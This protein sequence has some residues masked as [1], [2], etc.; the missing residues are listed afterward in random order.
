VLA[1]L[2]LSQIGE[3]SFILART[4]AEFDL[5]SGRAFQLFLDVT[6]LTMMA[7]PLII[8]AGPL[9]AQVLI[10]LPL[11]RSLV[12]GWMPLPQIV[13]VPAKDHLIIVGFGING[14]NV[15]RA[16]RAANIAY[17]II[18]TNP[19]TVRAEQAKGEPII[20]GDATQEHV[21]EHA[22]IADARVMAIAISDP[23]A[24]RRV[25]EVARRINP[26]LYIIV[27]T[28][29]LQEIE[30]LRQLGANE[31]IPEEFETSIE[32][33]S[34]VLATYLIPE[35]DIERFINEVRADSY[36]MLRSIA[37]ARPAFTKLGE[38][39]ADIELTS[40]RVGDNSYVAGKTL[41]QIQL[42]RAHKVSAIAIRRDPELITNP[43]ADSM[44][45]AGDLV[46]VVGTKEDIKSVEPIFEGEQ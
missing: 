35:R 27:R 28:R 23:A 16:A 4:G 25:V 14:R 33:F 15:A 38:Y 41:A 7:T 11:P 18:E 30:P 2:A 46:A 39:F 26:T 43:D 24:T 20:F 45:L 12:R 22:N 10:R 36:E 13:E 3:F 19:D 42:R 1:G 21:L 9:V 8:N 31:V 44:L 34:R 5:L 40:L 29:Y 32:I 17:I 6:I 37:G